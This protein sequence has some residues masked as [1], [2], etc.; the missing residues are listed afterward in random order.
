VEARVV[1]LKLGAA[2]LVLDFPSAPLVYV[3][4]PTRLLEY[5]N[6]NDTKPSTNSNEFVL[7]A[8]RLLDYMNCNETKPS[9]N[10]NE[11]VKSMTN[12]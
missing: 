5:M 9:T 6:C 12:L 3:S 2:L 4:K 11:T 8:L 10:S 7:F 1:N